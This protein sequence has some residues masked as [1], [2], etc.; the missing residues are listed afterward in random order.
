MPPQIRFFMAP[1]AGGLGVFLSATAVIELAAGWGPLERRPWAR[2]FAIVIGCLSLVSFPFGT[3]L[4]I[5][6]LWV[7]ASAGADAEYERLARV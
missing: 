1:M 6:T 5:Y 4:G 7:L 3:A 2:M